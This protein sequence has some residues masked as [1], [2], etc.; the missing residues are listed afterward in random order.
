[1][2]LFVFLFLIFA[3]CNIFAQANTEE[4]EII[5]IRPREYRASLVNFSIFADEQRVSKIANG[6]FLKYKMKA[7]KHFIS[8]Q[9]M[10]KRP[11]RNAVLTP[12]E[13]EAGKTKYVL[14]LWQQ[15]FWKNRFITAEII[16][17]SSK[18]FFYKL[19]EATIRP[20]AK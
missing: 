17:A 16:E 6:R 4:G 10:G 20:K 1:M 3:S 11:K 8:L 2:K 9:R 13:V 18:N 19:D 7:G 12:I 15:G 14:L 5:F